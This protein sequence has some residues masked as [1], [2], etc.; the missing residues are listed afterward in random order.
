M[1][2]V[3]AEYVEGDVP[4]LNHVR[5]RTTLGVDDGDNL[6]GGDAPTLS[7]DE[8]PS[9]GS[10][11]SWWQQKFREARSLRAGLGRWDR[12]ELP[13]H[14]TRAKKLLGPAPGRQ[15][16]TWRG[17]YDQMVDTVAIAGLTDGHAGQQALVAR[18]WSSIGPLAPVGD[19]VHPRPWAF[20]LLWHARRL[21]ELPAEDAEWLRTQM[22]PWVVPP[23]G[24]TRT[25]L[26]QRLVG[27]QL[28]LNALAHMSSSLDH[29]PRD[30]GAEV[31]RF[32]EALCAFELDTLVS[33]DIDFSGQ[34]HA[35]LGCLFD[36]A[37]DVADDEYDLSTAESWAA[38]ATGA[39]QHQIA[40][41]ETQSGY[42]VSRTLE[43]TASTQELVDHLWSE[44]DARDGQGAGSG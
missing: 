5:C 6:G 26:K 42:R 21:S 31:R 17:V 10:T 7:A 25:E 16:A 40:F 30:R 14:E 32:A 23:S 15:W 18:L 8:S 37:M 29:D 19:L 44:L 12:E 20:T 13:L 43:A 1:M 41:E 28:A 39:R 4:G 38:G 33:A 9:F 3:A 36:R 34:A 35:V 27:H 22:L 2:C 11:S 24:L